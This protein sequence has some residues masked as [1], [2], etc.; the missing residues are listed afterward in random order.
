MKRRTRSVLGTAAILASLALIATGCSS[1]GGGGSSTAAAGGVVYQTADGTCSGT[2]LSGVDYST[3]NAYVQSFQQ[4][5]TSLLETTPLPKPVGKDTTVVYLNN[6][7]AVA[8]LMQTSLQAAAD[9]AGVTLVNVSTGTDAQ[10]INAA[11]NSVV[12]MKPDIVISEAIDATF[13]QDQLKQL[14]AAGTVIVY[15]SQPNAAQFGLEDSLGGMNSSLVNGKVLA[16]GAI[17]YTCGTA[18]NFVFYNIPELGFS[19]IQL[20]AAQDELKTLCPDC[21]LRSVD[22][23]IS[24][25]SPADKIVSDLQSHP[26]TNFFIT[27]AD[28]FQVGLQDKANLAGITNAYGFGQSS[29]PPNIEQIANGQQTAGFAV[30]LNMYLYMQ[31][32]EGLRKAQNVWTPYSDWDAVNREVSRVLTKSNASQYL[33]GFIAYPNMQADFEKLWGK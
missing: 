1:S 5:P 22:I 23:S 2:P 26:E 19:A 13:W 25:P 8:G 6:D 12:E 24:D 11:L 14:Q 33:N 32:D 21:T 3:A 18:K 27:P 20:T 30:D 28:Q 31:L 15:G 17:A 7:T 29:L 16:A 9:S 4:N 10:S